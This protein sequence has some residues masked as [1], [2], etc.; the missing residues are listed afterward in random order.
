MRL[1]TLNILGKQR[2]MTVEFRGLNQTFAVG[3]GEF[4]DM[5]NITAANYPVLTPRLKRGFIKNFENP[6][7][8]ID[9]DK[10]VWVEN[11]HLY[12]NGKE[13]G[14]L[15]QGAGERQLVNMGGYLV[16]FPDNLYVNMTEG[17]DRVI[18]P[19]GVTVKT[20]GETKFELCDVDGKAYTID[21]EAPSAPT[22]IPKADGTE[23]EDPLP[24]GYLW[25]D[26]ENKSL[27]MWSTTT[28]VWTGVASTYIRITNSAFSSKAIKQYDTVTISGVLDNSDQPYLKHINEAMTV[29]NVGDNWISV[30]GLITK[31]VTQDAAITLERK[32]PKLDFVTEMNNRLWG[33]YFGLNE[34]NEP[35]NEIYACKQGDPT[36]WF[37]YMGLTG[38]SFTASV[39]SDGKWTGCT[40]YA[41]YVLFFKENRIHKVF[42]TKPSNFEI[43]DVPAYGVEE[44]SERSICQVNGGLFYKSRSG[45]VLYDGATPKLIDAALGESIRYS[46]ASAGT[47]GSR[48]FVSCLDTEDNWNLLV[49]DTE[50][51]LWLKED[52]TQ[53][54]FFANVGGTLYFIDDGDNWL[55]S[56][57][58][59]LSIYPQFNNDPFN[60]EAYS[61][62][63]VEWMVQTGDLGDYLPD[64]KYY[65]RLQ[66][67]MALGN[68]SD[69]D[70]VECKVLLRENSIG[71]FKEKKT[72]S[73]EKVKKAMTIP[74]R[75]ARCDHL[76]LRLEGKGDCTVWNISKFVE[77]GSEMR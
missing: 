49:Y 32:I 13:V 8:L 21:V 24:D 47:D 20:N 75:P 29:W 2:E 46:K 17:S 48:Y 59:T 56:T 5:K 36:N 37:S 1:P 38:D 3:D 19:L 68:E 9:K 53:A 14:E 4:A 58:G 27:K 60:E 44:G 35:I 71:E 12:M 28:G 25:Y 22:G 39:G 43:Q 15:E 40:S 51:G 61:E 69:G 57:T 66:I 7:G 76:S 63:A 73:G 55:K 64:N 54:R 30:T 34:D 33:C 50:K 10:M 65:S 62:P 52:A 67:R 45:F 70:E 16:I 11:D 74:I 23:G 26:T 31:T 72:I 42:G 6:Q 77:A 41:G 18:H